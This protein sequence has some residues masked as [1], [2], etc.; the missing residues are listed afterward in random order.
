[1]MAYK[2]SG[3]KFLRTFD[4]GTRWTHARFDVF[5]AVKIQIEVI[6]VVALCKLVGGTTLKMK[7][8]RFSETL[9][10]NHHTTWHNNPG[11]RE[12]C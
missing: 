3:G 11:N 1:M 9:I 2:G 6:W 4:F 5:T 8:G 7:A 12:F 10:T